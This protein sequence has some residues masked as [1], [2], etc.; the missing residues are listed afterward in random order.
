MK[1]KKNIMS[2]KI[3]NRCLKIASLMTM[4]LTCFAGGITP[5]SI[6]QNII[7]YLTGNLARTVGALVVIGSGYAHLHLQRLSKQKF[8]AIV[9]GMSL[10]FGGAELADLW[11]G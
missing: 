1:Q 4:P 8:I 9:V 2:Q 7:D 6:A 3:K 11:W 10:I 5:E